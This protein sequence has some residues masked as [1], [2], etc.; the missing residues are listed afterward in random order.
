MGYLK[1]ISFTATQTMHMTVQGFWLGVERV[2]DSVQLV[3]T[4]GYTGRFRVYLNPKS[5]YNNG[6]LGYV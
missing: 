1:L 5:M 6:L 3:K 2:L 4:I